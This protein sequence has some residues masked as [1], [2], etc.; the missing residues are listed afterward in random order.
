MTF[1]LDA[2][3]ALA[4]ALPD[5]HS[6][7]AEQLIGHATGS[8]PCVPTLWEYEILSGLRNAEARKRIDPDDGDLALALL[9]RLPVRM[10]R[11]VAA[12]VLSLAREAGVSTYDASYL[13][14]A[15]SRHLPLVT[16]DERLR[17]A[18]LAV[19]VAVLEW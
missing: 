2:S 5:E 19:G 9:Q 18:A 4:L 1:V 13:A 17:R 14:V 15:E 7:A 11:P 16:S 10:E 8:P 6:A 3:I 12:R